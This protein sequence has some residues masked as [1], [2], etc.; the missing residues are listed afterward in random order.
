M[1][2]KLLVGNWKMNKSL[3]EGRES[4]LAFEEATRSLREV[5][6]KGTRVDV[7]LAV[8]TLLLPDIAPRRRSVRV[9][10]QNAHWAT[11][12]AFTGETPVAHLAELSITG[13]LVAHS[14]RR[15]MNGETDA[16]AGKRTAALL[17]AGLECVLCVGETLSERE[18][19]CVREV[20]TR[21]LATAFSTAGLVT[22]E[23][24][25]GSDPAAPLLSI[26]YE[27]VWAIGTGK[28]ATPVEAQEAHAH[29]RAELSRLWGDSAASRMRLLY[30]GSVTLANAASFFSCPDVDGALVGGASLDPAAFAALC[31][32]AAI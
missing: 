29:I 26:A 11:N 18:A 5:G 1:R 3:R 10:A 6:E 27:P 28:A 21:Q 25:M 14:E 4:L 20:L 8:P 23:M 13:S 22:S 24:A 15:Q 16:T 12:G 31:A 9:Y 17:K 7:G 19:G 32:A 2:R 30:G